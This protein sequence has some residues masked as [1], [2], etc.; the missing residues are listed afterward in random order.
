M[1]KTTSKTSRETS[2]STRLVQTTET[3]CSRK[4]AFLGDSNFPHS[5]EAFKHGRQIQHYQGLYER[6]S[7]LG[8]S[9]AE[10]RPV[11]IAGLEQRLMTALKS[12]GGYGVFHLNFYRDLLWHR[13]LGSSTLER[14]K[15]GKSLQVPS[16]SWMAFD[17]EIRYMNAPLGGVNWNPEVMSPFKVPNPESQTTSKAQLP[18]EFQAP[19]LRLKGER[20]K[21]LLQ[22]EPSR[23]LDEPLKCVIVGSDK[24]ASSKPRQHYA[25]ILAPS[26]KNGTHQFYER[27]G[28]AYLS[29]EEFSNVESQQETET[30]IIH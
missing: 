15:F 20:P 18:I 7:S 4:A 24:A 26:R 1:A 30:G 5:V 8:L 6:Y 11:A 19:V 2:Q 29:E 17:G 27:V 3:V 14:I 13:Q 22:D 12:T 23:E 28:V 9:N 16:W 21:L 25:I 10:D